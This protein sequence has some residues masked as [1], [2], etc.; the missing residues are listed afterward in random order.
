MDAGVHC[1]S[2][3]VLVSAVIATRANLSGAKCFGNALENCSRISSDAISD[4]SDLLMDAV[5]AYG[6]KLALALNTLGLVFNH[7]ARLSQVAYSS[8]GGQAPTCFGQGRKSHPSPFAPFQ[9]L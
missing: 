3:G 9:A 6:Y 4:F 5:V 2:F 1:C 7:M 8:S